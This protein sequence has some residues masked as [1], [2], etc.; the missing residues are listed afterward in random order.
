MVP[1]PPQ[2]QPS[3]S[4]LKQ[5]GNSSP[6]PPGRAPARTIFP[7]PPFHSG[8]K[9]PP[10]PSALPSRAPPAPLFSRAAHSKR[11]ILF[12]KQL[13]ILNSL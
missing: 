12:Y 8:S 5:P 11:Y 1:P 7:S 2:Q 4:A 10:P 6:P 13:Q 9:G 3:K